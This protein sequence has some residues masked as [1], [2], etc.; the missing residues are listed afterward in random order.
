M[1]HFDPTLSGHAVR[2]ASKRAIRFDQSENV[3]ARRCGAELRER[4]DLINL[5][6]QAIL[7]LGGG[8]GLES[9][10]L[11]NKYPEALVVGLDNCVDAA[12]DL[13]AVAPPDAWSA[14][15]GDAHEL[16]FKDH[17][18]DFVFANLILPWTDSTDAL[19]EVARVLKPGG[20]MLL[21]TFGPDTLVELRAAWADVDNKP[22]GHAFIDMHDLGDTIL[23]AGFLEPV[24]DVD[25]VGLTY[26]SVEGLVKDL[27]M[28]GG[29]NALVDRRRSLTG[30]SRWQTFKSA[31]GSSS[32]DSDRLRATFELIYGVAWARIPPDDRERSIEVKF[33]E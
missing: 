1:K 21:A 23:Q 17:C 29:T 6:P 31:Y 12:S 24:M 8:M 14:C 5:Q 33:G 16:P 3:I 4:L 9:R 28:L 7:D 10:E 26:L 13:K 27:R 32:A 19:K 15:F 25:V 20:L 30:K 22:H 18:F 2:L 11:A